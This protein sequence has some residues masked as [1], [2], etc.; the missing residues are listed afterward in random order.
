MKLNSEIKDQIFS[1]FKFK[2]I[3]A[4]SSVTKIIKE[5]YNT[6]FCKNIVVT[7]YDNDK[8]K[9]AEYNI[10]ETVYEYHEFAKNNLVL[11]SQTY[12]TYKNLLEIEEDENC[13][14]I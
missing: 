2:F 9:N 4:G 1:E 13:I 5:I 7:M 12:V 11:D 10:D 3:T 6:Y 8:D 14:E